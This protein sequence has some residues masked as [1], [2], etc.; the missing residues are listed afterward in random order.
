MTASTATARRPRRAAPG[1]AHA[2]QHWH[3]GLPRTRTPAPDRDACSRQR[4]AAEFTA[5][6]HWRRPGAQLG[7]VA[8][9]GK[10][11]TAPA[12][13][14]RTGVTCGS[15]QESPA[16]AAAPPLD[17]WTDWAAFGGEADGIGPDPEW[18]AELRAEA[19]DDLAALALEP[20]QWPGVAA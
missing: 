17:R 13:A 14:D 10:I 7:A 20:V 18:Y 1:T 8:C 11:T 5:P 15:C 16:W 19:A 9:H 3:H 4:A 6:V 2:P 12:T